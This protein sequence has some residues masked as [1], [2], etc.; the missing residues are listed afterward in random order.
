MAEF[1]LIHPFPGTNVRRWNYGVIAGGGVEF[2]FSELVGG[3]VELSISPD[4][5]QQ[6]FQNSFTYTSNIN[7]QQL[8]TIGERRIRNISIELS[9]GFRF[10]RIVEYIDDVF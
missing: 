4:I 3:L 6:Y 9:V 1:N 10:L 8:R 7:G 2:M 5:S